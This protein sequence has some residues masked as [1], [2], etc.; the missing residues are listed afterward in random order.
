MKNYIIF[1]IIIFFLWGCTNDTSTQS[2]WN[3]SASTPKPNPTIESIGPDGIVFAGVDVITIKGT[4]FSSNIAENEVYFNGEKGTIKSAT[5]TE[6]KVVSPPSIIGDS[7]KVQVRVM[8]ALLYASWHDQ[9]YIPYKLS[10]V[11]SKFSDYDQ[12]DDIF[13]LAIDRDGNIYAS[14]TKDAVGNLKVIHKITPD[15]QHQVYAKTSFNKASQMKIGPGGD[16][17]YVNVLNYM[18]IVPKDAGTDK[19][20]A[21]LPGGVFDLD[22]N[23]NGDIYCGGSGQAVYRIKPDKSVST[24][25]DYTDINIRAI[26]VFNNYV[27]IAGT[28]SGS[29]SSVPVEGIWRNKIN[30]DGRLATKELVFNWSDKFSGSILSLAF[31]EDGDMYVGTNSTEAIV[32]VHNNS[33]Y[34]TLYP[35]VLYPETYSM[36]WGNGVY[37]YIV[38]RNS[39]EKLRNI[40]KVNLRKNTAPYYGRK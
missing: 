36:S 37:L 34:E 3:P 11:A 26:R 14:M 23:S 8:G 6:I 29:D 10:L 35:G 40:M 7:I 12:N 32:V 24:V 31:S 38:R 33:S 19:I 27:Y 18:F 21:I 16:L 13:G 30:T 39:D 22:F 5:P 2:I 17:Y 25:A 20:Y 9:F 15:G 1:N 28:Y 4:N